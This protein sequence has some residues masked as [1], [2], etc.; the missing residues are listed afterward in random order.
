MKTNID[1]ATLQAAIDVACNETAKTH[2]IYLNALDLKLDND[3]WADESPARLTLARALLARLPEPTPPTAD[4]K[5]PGQVAFEAF[6]ARVGGWEGSSYKAEYEKSASAVL[7]AFGGQS[8]LELKM[9]DRAEKAEAELGNLLAIIHRDG[10]H[11][12]AEYG[13]PKAIQEAHQVIGNKEKAE[14][15]LDRIVAAAHEAG[16]NGVENPKD[17]AQFI[18]R[19]AEELDRIKPEPAVPGRDL[20]DHRDTESATF[21]A[22]GT[23]WT[24][25]SPGDPMPVDT[26]TR[27]NVLMNDGIVCEDQYVE[28]AST[29]ACIIGWRYAGEL[30]PEPKPWQPAVGDVVKANPV[31]DTSFMGGTP[32]RLHWSEAGPMSAQAPDRARKGSLNSLALGG[33]M[34]WRDLA[35]QLAEV[36]WKCHNIGA[37]LQH[38]DIDTDV[39]FSVV[40]EQ[41]GGQ[42]FH[43][44]TPHNAWLKAEK[45]LMSPDRANFP[46]STL[47]TA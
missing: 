35:L 33:Q 36:W 8:S 41:H 10:G 4:G 15:E 7:A 34:Y 28:F 43:A 26:V 40:C 21:E 31:Q 6:Q 47:T 38:G 9:Q 30:A 27:I 29:W 19:Q 23:T 46:A 11:Y 16:W 37:S 20:A 14:A 2:E 24:R 5:T 45:W 42:C 44:D 17:L 12:Q 39:S 32:R 1:D 18:K 3:Y 13:S 25:H 22:H